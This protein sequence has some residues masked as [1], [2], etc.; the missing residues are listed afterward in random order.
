M[1]IRKATNDGQHEEEDRYT[2]CELEEELFNAAP[3]AIDRTRV[4][5]KSAA[6]RRSLC[7]KQYHQD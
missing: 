5:S 6:K 3:G 1:L 2:N 4:A 7:L